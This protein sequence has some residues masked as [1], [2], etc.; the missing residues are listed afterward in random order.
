MLVLASA[1]PRRKELMAGLGLEFQVMAA[2]V[3]EDQIPGETAQDMVMRL[4]LDKASALAGRIDAGLVIGAD[5]TVVLDGEVFGKPVDADD[6]R[7]ML[8]RLSGTQH[9]VMTGLSVVNAATGDRQTDFMASG[10]K[11]RDLSDSEISASIQLG[12]LFD[13]AGAYAVQDQELRPAEWWR[14]CYS[15]I[16]GLP[17]CRLVDM[18]Q[19]L[20]YPLPDRKTL[21]APA[22]CIGGPFQVECPFQMEKQP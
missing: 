12:T 5:S 22:G 8:D 14:G 9:Q 3:P 19:A 6:A 13:K 7:Q 11:L 20:G 21:R 17:L 16:V 18:L 1:S 4:S 15:N 2:D 10:I